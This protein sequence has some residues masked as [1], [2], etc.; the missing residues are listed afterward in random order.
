ACAA[1]LP[2]DTRRSEVGS[3]STVLVSN[4]HPEQIHARR[5]TVS[6]PAHPTRSQMTRAVGSS[7]DS[8]TSPPPSSGSADTGEF[9]LVMIGGGARAAYQVGMLRYIARRYQELRF[10]IPFGTSAGAVTAAY[11]AQH[12]GTFL[13]AVEDLVNLWQGLLPE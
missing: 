6:V 4:C 10:R 9:A 5:A 7:S 3:I 8:A 11:L 1:L 12:R 2:R 13:E